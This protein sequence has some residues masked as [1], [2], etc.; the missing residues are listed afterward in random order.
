MFVRF[1]TQTFD[2]GDFTVKLRTPYN[3][4]DITENHH[5][6]IVGVSR[7][8]FPLFGMVWPAGETLAHLMTLYPLAGKRIL[9][10]GCGLGLATHVLNLRGADV[11]ALDI[12]PVADEL[13]QRNAKL[14]KSPPIPFVGASWSD[15]AV[16]L[17]A[18]DLVI[19]SDVLYEPKHVDHLPDFIARHT[20]RDSEVLIVDPDRG[21]LAGF[22]ARM[23]AAGFRIAAQAPV[24]PA[25][26]S[27][28]YDIEI[29]SFV[30][31]C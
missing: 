21:P 25:G 10:V 5:R 8:A 19:G 26:V 6:D 20:H 4:R 22:S 1:R 27:Q 7:D 16:N 18:F 12:H 24:L 17:G 30:N 31:N 23:A 3:L 9:D 28:P 15:P 14:N 29:L 2:V 13:L 11:T